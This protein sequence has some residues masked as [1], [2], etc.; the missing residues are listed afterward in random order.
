MHE[1]SGRAQSPGRSALNG[2]E[3]DLSEAGH[4]FNRANK[5]LGFLAPSGAEA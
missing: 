1:L 2:Y 4:G 5:G 3:K